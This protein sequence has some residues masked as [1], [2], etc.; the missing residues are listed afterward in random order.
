LAQASPPCLSASA[1]VAPVRPSRNLYL[2]CH[3]PSQVL[4]AWECALAPYPAADNVS[5][6]G[7]RQGSRASWPSRASYPSPLLPFHALPPWCRSCSF[8]LRLCTPSFVS[9]RATFLSVTLCLGT[10]SRC[11]GSVLVLI[12]RFVSHGHRRVLL[13]GTPWWGVAGVQHY[14]FS[15]KGSPPDC[16]IP[17][18]CGWISWISCLVSLLRLRGCARHC[19]LTLLSLRMSAA[20]ACRGFLTLASCPLVPALFVLLSARF[21]PAMSFWLGLLLLMRPCLLVNV[22]LL[23][24]W[25]RVA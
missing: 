5:A 4:V 21:L 2:C 20:F 11:M 24:V 15:C 19:M 8:L 25:C 6:R 13:G 14:L 22:C 9:Y 18:I 1:R 12:A 23:L 7:R 10:P 17:L 3:V 16:R